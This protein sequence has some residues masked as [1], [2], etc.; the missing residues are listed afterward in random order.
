MLVDENRSE[1][2]NQR[3]QLLLILGIFDAQ[4]LRPPSD[5]APGV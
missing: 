2:A 4:R 5:R 3:D 1:L